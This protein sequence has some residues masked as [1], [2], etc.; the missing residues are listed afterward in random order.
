MERLW[1]RRSAIRMRDHWYCSPECLE[2]AMAP[3]FQDLI[4][5]PDQRIRHRIPLGLL[6]LA[7][8]YLNSTQLRAGLEAQRRARQGKIGH[9]LQELDFV[10]EQQVI[11]TLGLQWGCPVLAFPSGFDVRLRKWIPEPLLEAL[12][13]MPV[14][15]VAPTQVLY[16]AVCAQVEHAALYAMERMLECRAVACLI[17]DRAMAELREQGPRLGGIT[18]QLFERL[19][20]AN[21]MASITASYAGRLTAEEVRIELCGPYLWVRLQSA[22]GHTHLLFRRQSGSAF[23]LRAPRVK[24]ATGMS[25][26]P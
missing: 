17:S 2:S 15:F 7:R 24:S 10:T 22:P 26:S 11:T 12:G 6:L 4:S 18:S 5:R 8:G 14:R 20:S 3:I 23:G 16:V 25:I 9:W 1:H 21:E 19:S 13:M